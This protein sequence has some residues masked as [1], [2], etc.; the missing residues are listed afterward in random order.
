MTEAD[1][2][3]CLDL[4]KMLDSL[5]HQKI[6]Q[7]KLRLFACACCRQIWPLLSDP[8]REAVTTAEQFA[9]ELASR[10]QLGV[11]LANAVIVPGMPALAAANAA[12]IHIAPLTHFSP[13]LYRPEE[14]AACYAAQAARV[15]AVEA[16]EVTAFEARNRQCNLLRCVWNPHF[17]EALPKPWLLSND[18]AVKRIAEAIYEE[19]RYEDMPII[20][21]ALEE[22]GCDHEGMLT[23]CRLG[24]PHVRGCWVIDV[25]RD[26]PL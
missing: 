4:H 13:T 23:H 18:S 2:L 12:T 19:E 15:A 21:D 11:A 25:I 9:E 20:G 7:R 22:A 10:E 14:S 5:P 8:S 16:G 17:S 3:A 6:S 24:G 26:T 1:W